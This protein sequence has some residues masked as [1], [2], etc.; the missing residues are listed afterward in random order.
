MEKATYK[1]T[2]EV[3]SPNV[4]ISPYT[5]MNALFNEGFYYFAHGYLCIT[6]EA[7]LGCLGAVELHLENGD[8]VAK[9]NYSITIT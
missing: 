7:T 4:F 2:I 3:E 9:S 8:V 1:L 6:R 5:V